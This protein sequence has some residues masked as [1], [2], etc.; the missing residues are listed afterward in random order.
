[1]FTYTQTVTPVPYPYATEMVATVQIENESQKTITIDGNNG[2]IIYLTRG[3][4]VNGKWLQ[5]HGPD[6]PF[7]GGGVL[8]H[9]STSEKL[10]FPW[11]DLIKLG[12][13]P[14]EFEMEYKGDPFNLNG[15]PKPLIWRMKL[16]IEAQQFNLVTVTREVRVPENLADQVNGAVYE[17]DAQVTSAEQFDTAL[18]GKGHCSEVLHYNAMD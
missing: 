12:S 7:N 14:M 13:G 9:G 4:S 1:V 5:V 8:V 18:I 6:M 3:F 16:S 2:G 11:Q 10:S 15:M 17:C